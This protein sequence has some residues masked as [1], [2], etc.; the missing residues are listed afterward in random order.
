LR[1]AVNFPLILIFSVALTY[2]GT[3]YA[4]TSIQMGERSYSSWA[5]LVWPV[6][7]MLPIGSFLLV[8]QAISDFLRDL[9]M[10]E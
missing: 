1:M 2:M 6:K 10:A 3:E 7:M 4:W 9:L 8:L 5:P